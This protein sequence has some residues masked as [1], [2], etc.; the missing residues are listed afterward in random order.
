MIN[1][2]MPSCW[3][4][5]TT[6]LQIIHDSSTTITSNTLHSPHISE[7]FLPS[8]R[9]MEVEILYLWTTGFT[10]QHLLCPS[11]NESDEDA[12]DC[13]AFSDRAHQRDQ[14]HPRK[15]HQP[16]PYHGRT[17]HGLKQIHHGKGH[18]QY[19][20]SRHAQDL[21]DPSEYHNWRWHPQH[22]RIIHR[23]QRDTTDTVGEH[24]D[25]H[26]I[27]V[28]SFFCSRESFIFQHGW[29]CRRIFRCISQVEAKASSLLGNDSK[30]K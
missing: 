5:T 8:K 7:S 11:T 29:T 20:G 4:N 27:Y 15:V 25:A 12:F 19:F 26:H 6:T 2:T 30:K 1:A 28:V 24:H 9:G 23:R 3:S 22:K 16:Q 13:G 10:R 14:L 21:W 18:W 17:D